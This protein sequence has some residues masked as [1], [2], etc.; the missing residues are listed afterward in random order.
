[1]PH[2]AGRAVQGR[3]AENAEN[4]DIAVIADMADIA[5]NIQSTT[6]VIVKSS[7]KKMI[8]AN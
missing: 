5:D 6:G 3:N 2:R 7:G 4:A 1:M 8:G